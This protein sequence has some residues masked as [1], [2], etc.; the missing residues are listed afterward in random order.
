MTCYDLDDECSVLHRGL[1][2]TT[3]ENLSSM[4]ITVCLHS[5]TQGDAAPYSRECMDL[6]KGGPAKCYC[7]LSFPP[8]SYL[9]YTLI[10]FSI[11]LWLSAAQNF[12]VFFYS[13]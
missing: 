10:L 8:Y 4:S 12:F 11:L 3:G 7:S 6:C 2:Q 1:M 13:K 5:D 9:T